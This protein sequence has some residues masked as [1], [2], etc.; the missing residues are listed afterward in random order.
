MYTKGLF[1]SNIVHKMSECVSEHFFFPE[2]IHP[3]HRCGISICWLDNMIV[4]QVCRRLVTNKGHS[5]MCTFILE[6]HIYYCKNCRVSENQSDSIWCD[7]RLPHAVQ[8]ISFIELSTVKTGIYPWKEHLS[9][10]PDAFEGERLRRRT[11]FKSGPGWGRRACRWASLETVS[12]SLCRSYF[13]MQTDCCISWRVAGLRQSCRWRCRMWRSWLCGYTWSAV[14]RPVG[15][16]ETP[17][18]MVY[19]MVIALVDIPAVSMPIARSRDTV[20]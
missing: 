11:A 18:E 4:A 20:W 12:D 19:G 16:T 14:V 8:H 3:P 6:R 7:Q 9:E 13:V 15:Y 17:L 2:I 10:V 5:K 1:L